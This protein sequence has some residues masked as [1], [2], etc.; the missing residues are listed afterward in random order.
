MSPQSD[1]PLISTVVKSSALDTF[2]YKQ[3]KPLFQEE[4]NLLFG[5]RYIQNLPEV[6]DDRAS[7]PGI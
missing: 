3:H 2:I 6:L 7:A 1:Q 4:H 5:T